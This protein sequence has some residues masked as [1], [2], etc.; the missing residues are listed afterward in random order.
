MTD[1]INGWL[2]LISKVNGFS[3][4]MDMH[5]EDARLF[6]EEVIV[7]GR[8]V[9]AMFKQG[10]HHRIHFVL[11]QNQIA[12]HHFFAAVTFGHSEPATK[13]KRSGQLVSRNGYVQVIPW[14]VDLEDVGFVVARLADDLHDSLIVTWR[15][16]RNRNC[17][18]GAKNQDGKKNFDSCFSC[19]CF[20]FISFVTLLSPSD[21]RNRSLSRLS[22][23]GRSCQHP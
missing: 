2:D 22:S 14:N 18:C 17:G 16:L 1:Q 12:H 13:T 19:D 20:H 9:E 5:K 10:G 8:D 6:P 4:A 11:S 23:R 7:Q 15:F 21:R 3:M